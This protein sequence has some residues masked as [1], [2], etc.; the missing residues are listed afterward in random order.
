MEYGLNHF[1]GEY[2]GRSKIAYSLGNFAV[3]NFTSW[4][5][6]YDAGT[7]QTIYL[8]IA[9]EKPYSIWDTHITHTEH[10]VYKVIGFGRSLEDAIDKVG[11]II[12][13]ST[14]YFRHTNK[15]VCPHCGKVEYDN[16]WIEEY[17]WSVSNNAY[18]YQQVKH[19]IN[20]ENGIEFLQLKPDERER[21]CND[22]E[23][24]DPD[25]DD[26]PF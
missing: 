11:R 25:Y 24:Y 13:G 7:E 20:R 5:D 23:E 19:L 10:G 22:C 21:Y 4:I 8:R 26:L 18:S 6:G 17:T 9:D 1:K 16:W 12:A 2:I 3:G 15:Y 14:L